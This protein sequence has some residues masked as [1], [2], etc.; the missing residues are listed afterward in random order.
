LA[1]AALLVRLTPACKHT[2]AGGQL[3][4]ME[5]RVRQRNAKYSTD[6]REFIHSAIACL[7]VL[8]VPTQDPA[9]EAEAASAEAASVDAYGPTYSHRLSNA[10]TYY[11]FIDIYL[12][13]SNP[14]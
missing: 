5:A 14:P 10:S 2:P 12:S 9:E 7:V 13:A 1:E 6:K 11:S 8:V 4:I 3:S